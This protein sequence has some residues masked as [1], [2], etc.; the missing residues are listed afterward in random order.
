MSA[1]AIYM[2]LVIYWFILLHLLKFNS[3]NPYILET[4]KTWICSALFW[5]VETCLEL[6]SFHRQ[7]E[8]TD[9]NLI[10]NVDQC[11]VEFHIARK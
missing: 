9:D 5:D 8:S 2:L 7:I 3:W 1:G 4:E 6:L 11:Y 10:C